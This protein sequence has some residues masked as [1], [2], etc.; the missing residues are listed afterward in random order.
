MPS[1]SLGILW[2]AQSTLIGRVGVGGLGGERWEQMGPVQPG[3]GD[4]WDVHRA[5]LPW[6]LAPP[7]GQRMVRHKRLPG[8]CPGG[9]GS[10]GAAPA[11]SYPARHH[12]ILGPARLQRRHTLRGREAEGLEALHQD[13]VTEAEDKVW[14]VLPGS[15]LGPGSGQAGGWRLGGLPGTALIS[16]RGPG[17]GLRQNYAEGRGLAGQRACKGR[18]ETPPEAEGAKKG[19]QGVPRGKASLC[20]AQ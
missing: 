7:L 2:D 4:S 16:P 15:W 9:R 3:A 10:G 18:P 6:C 20:P 12:C 1:K 5:H 13:P 8:A 17:I 14:L 11:Q 19:P